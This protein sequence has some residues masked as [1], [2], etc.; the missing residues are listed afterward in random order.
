MEFDPPTPETKKTKTRRYFLTTRQARVVAQRREQTSSAR[1]KRTKHGEAPIRVVVFNRAFHG[2][3][4]PRRSLFFVVVF[5]V[6]KFRARRRRRSSA[7]PLG[8]EHRL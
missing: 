1:A 7:R 4:P 5:V 2:D 6:D 8:R 3:S